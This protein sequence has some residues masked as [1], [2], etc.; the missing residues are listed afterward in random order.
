[1]YR[2]TQLSLRQRS[3][4]VLLTILIV[5]AGAFGVTRLRSELL[6]NIEIPVLTVI[7]TNP[8]AGPEAIDGSIS[9]PISQALTGLQGLKSVTAQSSE[10][11][12]V[13]VAEFDY[14]ENMD[15]RQNDISQ[16][17]ANVTMPDGA[18]T[19]KI[20]RINLQQFPVIQ[21]ALTSPDNDLAKLR[22][23]AESAIVPRLSSADGVSRVEVVGGSTDQLMIRLDPNKMAAAGVSATQVTGALQANNVSIPAGTVISGTTSLPVRVNSQITSKEALAGLVV[24][25]TTNASGQPQPV[26]LGSIAKVEVVP[27]ETTGIARTNGRPSIA[28][29][30]YMSQDA[31]T[32][33]TAASVRDQLDKATANIAANGT[34]INATVLLD[35]STYIQSSI[36]SLIREA[37][38]GAVFAILV[39]L[40]F[41]MS[42]RSTL[43]TAI[44]IPTSMLIAFI[45]L[46]WQ[47]IS[48]NIM[49]LGGL[50][51]AVGRVVDDSIVVLESIFRH[52]NRGQDRRTATIEG[53]REVALAITASTLTTVAVFLP[54]AVVGGLIGEIFRP[55]ALTVT[56]ALFASL[57]VALTIVPVMAS[58]FIKAGKAPATPDGRVQHPRIARY[59]EP[60]LRKTLARP[61]ITLLIVAIVFIGSLGLTP[62]IGTSFLPSSGQKGATVTIDLPEGTAQTTTVQ[63]VQ[64]FEQLIQKSADVK[65]LQTTVG[66]SDLAAVFT[67]ASGSRATITVVFEDSV[68]LTKTLDALRSTL[69]ANK[70]NADISVA[71]LDTQGGNNIQVI[72]KGS[73]YQAVSGAATKLT[74]RLQ[75]VKN[76]VNVEN[77]VVASKPE[78]TVTID[79]AKAAA[80]GIT[81][82]QVGQQVRTALAGMPAGSITIGSTTYPAV[83]TIAGAANPDQLA[84]LPVAG[85]GKVRL[86]QVATIKQ[87]AGPVRVNRIDG[88]RSATITGTITS[89][90]T[91]GVNA[92]VAKIVNGFQAP[93]GVTVQIGGIGQDQGN[94]FTSMGIAMVVAI[95][96]VYIIMVASFGSLTTPFVILFSLPLAV[97]GVLVALFVSGKTIGL[98]AL[99]GVLMLIGIVVTN[100]IVLLEFVIELRHRGLELREALVEGGKTRLRPILMTAVATILALVPLALSQEGGAIIASDLA[101]VVIGGLVTSTLLTLIVVPVIYEL[102]AGWQD[103][104][105][106]RREG[107]EAQRA[108]EVARQRETTAPPTTASS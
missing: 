71:N 55:F 14:G 56:F 7:T 74:T 46:W 19:P 17:I 83:L 67:G 24:G 38:L 23:T 16:A 21:L 50:A 94:A 58:L 33:D 64:N 28:V 40:V 42:V 98:P 89:D 22:Q 72:V 108:A 10:G 51:V 86:D 63:K 32:V 52:V 13:V 54:L 29:N 101:V 6:P 103:R 107:R 39:I 68:N 90:S 66:G 105:T 81:T 61:V 69:D 65:T 4:V 79:P 49:T 104:R 34:H 73:D 96:A 95:A 76:L 8:G 3:V 43:V 88:D 41:L 20:Q 84:K 59:Y 60:I 45:I 70:G 75:G 57:L 99:I 91:G 78:L 2:L 36:N 44:S 48:L 93:E 77:D 26:T 15:K 27:V 18:G 102:I 100:A 82:A 9:Q 35:Q 31:N 25:A 85:G 47:G 1:M 62:F 80:A 11:I 12:S 37:L 5:M 106:A 30:V 92:D 53:T 87:V 97:I